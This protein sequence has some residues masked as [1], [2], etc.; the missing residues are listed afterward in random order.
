MSSCVLISNLHPHECLHYAWLPEQESK[1]KSKEPGTEQSF[2]RQVT[3][4]R[5][6][7]YEYEGH[8]QIIETL[9]A[10]KNSAHSKEKREDLTGRKKEG[11]SAVSKHGDRG[12]SEL[13]SDRQLVPTAPHS[14]KQSMTASSREAIDLPTN[15][16]ELD[17]TNSRYPSL[18]Y[19]RS[20]IELASVL[21]L[22]PSF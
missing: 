2:G 14:I 1:D 4:Y 12:G 17:P 11:R 9:G 16:P 20:R 15:V 13:G 3:F 19:P 10:T 21:A 7:F 22:I 8:S 6:H 5:R 18:N